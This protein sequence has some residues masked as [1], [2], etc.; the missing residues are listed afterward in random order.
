MAIKSFKKYIEKKNKY[1]N[2]KI[3]IDGIK[4]DSLKEAKR[5]GELKLLLK[6][7]KIK[8]LRLQPEFILQ[9]SF[10]RNGKT[11]RAIKYIADFSYTD[12]EGNEVIEDTKG[13]KT[14]IFRLKEKLF[15]YKYPQK[16]LILL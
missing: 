10:K 14:E 4:F 13:Y 12:K 15:Y 1:G 3:V 16:K 2:T 7:G 9:P 11:I 5:Y 6:A 8:N